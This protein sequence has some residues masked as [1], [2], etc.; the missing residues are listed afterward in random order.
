MELLCF[1]QQAVKHAQLRATLLDGKYADR[2]GAGAPVYLAAAVEYLE[3]E[4]LELAGNAAIQVIARKIAKKKKR[5]RIT[6]YASVK[7]H[8]D[9]T[10][11]KPIVPKGRYAKKFSREYWVVRYESEYLMLVK[12]LNMN[13]HLVSLLLCVF[14]YFSNSRIFMSH[15]DVS[16]KFNPFLKT[17]VIRLRNMNPIL[18]KGN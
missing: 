15:I 3:A 18:R 2:D 9:F 16:D 6:A 7:L 11:V 5:V 4:I 14:R 8:V 12:L 10:S 17:L 13:L 1:P